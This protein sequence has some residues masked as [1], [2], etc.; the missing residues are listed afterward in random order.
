ME[1]VLS[2]IPSQDGSRVDQFLCQLL[3]I[4]LC[5]PSQYFSLMIIYLK[6]QFCAKASLSLFLILTGCIH[7]EIVSNVCGLDH[8]EMIQTIN[9][10]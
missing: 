6:L 7:S 9:E 4:E 8:Q 10:M 2:Y 3:L 1:P 5:V